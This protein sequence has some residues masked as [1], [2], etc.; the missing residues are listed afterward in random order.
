[1]ELKLMFQCLPLPEP[2]VIAICLVSKPYAAFYGVLL[3]I[4]GYIV[5][6]LEGKNRGKQLRFDDAGFMKNMDTLDVQ[7]ASGRS[8]MKQSS[9][10]TTETIYPTFRPRDIWEDFQLEEGADQLFFQFQLNYIPDKNQNQIL[11]LLRKKKTAKQPIQSSAKKFVGEMVG[12]WSAKKSS[13]IR[14]FLAV[15]REK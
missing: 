14:R 10:A 7:S 9:F 12:I 1:M 6:W 2:G 11:T 4:T 13:K 3:F 15:T 5:G 8:T